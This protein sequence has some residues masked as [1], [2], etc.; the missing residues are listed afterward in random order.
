MRATIAATAV[1]L[2]LL[3]LTAAT[4]QVSRRSAPGHPGTT[5]VGAVPAA[6]EAA[7]QG[8]TLSAT[9]AAALLSAVQPPAD[10][11]HPAGCYVWQQPGVALVPTALWREGQSTPELWLDQSRLRGLLL[12]LS[13]YSWDA[14]AP[15]PSETP[16]LYAQPLPPQVYFLNADRATSRLAD[17]YARYQG[18]VAAN[19]AGSA[20]S[21]APPAAATP[22]A[23]NPFM[24]VAADAL[25]ADFAVVYLT[26]DGPLEFYLQYGAAGRLYVRHMISWSYFSA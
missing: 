15:F 21:S 11:L 19:N 25:H 9:F 20:E 16:E 4:P 10:V 2:G 24:N 7:L 5:A 17:Y 6:S 1:M 3:T 23:F 14:P 18:W 22:P 26:A 8:A 12:D 13:H